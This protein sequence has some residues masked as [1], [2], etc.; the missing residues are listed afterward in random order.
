MV[1]VGLGEWVVCSGKHLSNESR[2]PGDVGFVFFFFGSGILLH[3]I[4]PFHLL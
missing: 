2:G 3:A 4:C 1:C